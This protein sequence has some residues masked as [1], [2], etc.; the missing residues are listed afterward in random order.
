MAQFIS[1]ATVRERGQPIR[2]VRLLRHVL[3]IVF[4]ADNFYE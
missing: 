3:G 4:L 2:K 1:Q